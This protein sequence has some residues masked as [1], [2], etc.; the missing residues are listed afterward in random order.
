MLATDWRDEVLRTRVA[1]R[2][3]EEGAAVL[4]PAPDRRHARHR[5]RRGL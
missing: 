2:V 4:M 1:A 5:A 3:G